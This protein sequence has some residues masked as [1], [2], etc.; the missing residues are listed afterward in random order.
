MELPT[1][2]LPSAKA[3][4]AVGKDL[5][6]SKDTWIFSAK[7]K[8]FQAVQRTCLNQDPIHF[9][10]KWIAAAPKYVY[11]FLENTAKPVCCENCRCVRLWRVNATNVRGQFAKRSIIALKQLLYRMWH[12]HAG[13]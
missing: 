7:R 11:L 9:K 4:S 3:S 12:W 1:K 13:K 2:I 5:C 6:R 8:L 10:S